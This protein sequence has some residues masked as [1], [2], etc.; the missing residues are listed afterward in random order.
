[1]AESGGASGTS[2]VDATGV[3]IDASGNVWATSCTN[4]SIVQI[5][6][7][8]GAAIT[9]PGLIC[10]GGLAFDNSG[11]LW[12]L[13]AGGG[14]VLGALAQVVGPNVTFEVSPLTD[15]NFGGIAFSPAAAGLP[16]HQ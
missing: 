8:L 7:S 4:N 1:V 15:V 6:P 5:T 2:F 16:I 10:P 14:Q 3:A 13:S 11:N 12:V 9:D